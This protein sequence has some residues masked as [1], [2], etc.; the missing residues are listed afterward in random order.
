MTDESTI[1]EQAEANFKKYAVTECFQEPPIETRELAIGYAA[2]FARKVADDENRDLRERL[3]K[4]VQSFERINWRLDGIEK[5]TK[6]TR[7]N[8]VIAVRD[9]IQEALTGLQEKL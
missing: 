7:D 6:N 1:K 9:D 4:V 8:I 3:A 2:H 5:Q